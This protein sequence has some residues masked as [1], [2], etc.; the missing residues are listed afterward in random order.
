MEGG[1]LC[2]GKPCSSKEDREKRAPAAAHGDGYSALSCE[3]RATVT[4]KSKYD[5]YM[6]GRYLQNP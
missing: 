1:L 3:H 4:H 6:V 5:T 2:V